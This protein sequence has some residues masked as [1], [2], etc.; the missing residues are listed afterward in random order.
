MESVT[1]YWWVIVVV[2]LLALGGYVW[3]VINTAKQHVNSA[4]RMDMYMCDVHGPIP[5][6]STYVLFDGQE[7][8][9]VSQDG[10]TIRAQ[11]RQCPIC[12][13]SKIKEARTKN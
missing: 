1:W 2:L 10:R 11:V 5:G 9:Q 4:P 6:K 7:L 8:E 13:E 12:F 3:A